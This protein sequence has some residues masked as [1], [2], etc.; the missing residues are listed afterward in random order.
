MSGKRKHIAI[1]LTPTP[2]ELW[3]RE[4]RVRATRLAMF[5]C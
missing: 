4:Q 3:A 2:S 5:G 1:N